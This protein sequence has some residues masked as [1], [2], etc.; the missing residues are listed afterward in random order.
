M[1]VEYNPKNKKI[2]NSA[3]ATEE[4]HED[5]EEKEEKITLKKRG[6]NRS[7]VVEQNEYQGPFVPKKRNDQNLKKM[8]V[9]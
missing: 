9:S 2:T 4:D 5:P 1:G 6:L 7:C 8:Q 3:L